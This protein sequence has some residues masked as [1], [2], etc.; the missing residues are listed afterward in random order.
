MRRSII[1]GATV[2][3]SLLCNTLQAVPSVKRLTPPSALFTFNDSAPPYISRFM[4]GQRFDLQ[5]TVSPNP[6]Q[7][8]TNAQFS[9]D[10]APIS[11]AVNSTPATANGVP[12]N[13]VAMTLRAYGNQS[14]GVHTFSVTGF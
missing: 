6:G 2:F 14:A 11:G 7:T 3:G 8:I 10:G 9:V 12:A 13:S 4:P 5:A 1:I